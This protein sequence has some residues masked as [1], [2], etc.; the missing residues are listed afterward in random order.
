M[1][2]LEYIENGTY[3]IRKRGKLM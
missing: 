3:L 1:D 2:E